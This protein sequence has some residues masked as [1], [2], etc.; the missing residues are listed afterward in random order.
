M[1]QLH[2]FLLLADVAVVDPLALLLLP[3]PTHMV[4]SVPIL[5]MIR[6]AAHILIAIGVYKPAIAV[7]LMV[8]DLSFV[9][10][11]IVHDVSSNTIKIPFIVNLTLIIWENLTG[12]KLE[13]EFDIWH[14]TQFGNVLDFDGSKLLPFE[15]GSE[16]CFFGFCVKHLDQFWR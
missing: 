8:V 13:I 2:A 14:R 5:F 3:A 7:H 9:N 1:I 12:S 4:C 16:T 11:S 6:K 15:F 10:R